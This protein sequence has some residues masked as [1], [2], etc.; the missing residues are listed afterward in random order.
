[1]LV[2][3]STFIVALSFTGHDLYLLIQEQPTEK[4]YIKFA[5]V[6]LGKGILGLALYILYWLP[7]LKCS[8]YEHGW[9][10]FIIVLIF[11]TTVLGWVVAMVM[12][13]N[14]KKDKEPLTH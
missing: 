5:L 6:P 4:E 7:V 14:M 2:L 8:K 11:G 1:M 10:V 13:I 9:V 3:L 12:A